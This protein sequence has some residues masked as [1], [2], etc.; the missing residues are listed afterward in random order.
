MSQHLRAILSAALA[1]RHVAVA[2]SGGVDSLTLM[3]FAHAVAEHDAQAER[4][5]AFHAVSPAVPPES[6]ARVRSLAEERGWALRI[7]DAG[8]TRDPEYLQNPVDRC[9]VCKTHLYE[10]L[11]RETA[12]TR[13]VVLSGANTDDLNDYRPGLDAA[14]AR[15]V[16]HPF[17]EAGMDKRT[18]RAL[19]R[20][21]DLGGV[22]EL[23]AQP[24]LSSR[25]ETGIAIRAPLLALVN[26]VENAVRA[27]VR[28]N[29]TVRCRVRKTGVVIELE[30]ADLARL[31]ALTRENIV[32]ETRRAVRRA[33]L[34]TPIHVA[35]YRMGSAFLRVLT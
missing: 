19:A 25:I 13:A 27:R 21:L 2:V 4:L 14:A 24:C 30:D 32:D 9:R 20:S 18:V 26:D 10:T 35:P 5:T 23:P 17:V 1:Q 16:R 15:G 8:E 34:D 6:T 7:V 28:A 22:A 11:G 33:G 12:E 3:A 29:A 31:D